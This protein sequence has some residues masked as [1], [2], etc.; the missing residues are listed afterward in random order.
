MI[1]FHIYIIYIFFFIQM[2]ADGRAN[3][4]ERADRRQGKRTDGCISLI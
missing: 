3:V 4:S 1:S 2:G